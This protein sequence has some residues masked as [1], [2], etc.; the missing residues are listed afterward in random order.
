MFTVFSTTQ[1]KLSISE[2][3]YLYN[4]HK[5]RPNKVEKAHKVML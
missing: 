5:F 1:L 3:F 4:L 2:R